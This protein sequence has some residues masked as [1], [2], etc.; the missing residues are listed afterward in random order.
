MDPLKRLL[1]L[2]KDNDVQEIDFRFT[3]MG[4]KLHH[5]TYDVAIID[6]NIMTND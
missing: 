4:G 5:M 1:K 3:D 2:I 6:T